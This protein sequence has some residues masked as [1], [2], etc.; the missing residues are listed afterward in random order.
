MESEV[1]NIENAEDMTI[2]I[3]E[4]LTADLTALKSFW[5]S[6]FLKYI[7]A[8]LLIHEQ[9][10][11][12]IKILEKRLDQHFNEVINLKDPKLYDVV[13]LAES[14]IYMCQIKLLFVMNTEDLYVAEFFL[15]RAMILLKNKELCS[16]AIL[17]S[18]RALSNLN[19]V[20]TKLNN[21]KKSSQCLNK[22]M[23][24]YLAYTKGQDEFPAPISVETA[25]GIGIKFNTV[26]VLKNM[27]MNNLTILL[28]LSNRYMYELTDLEKAVTYIHNFLKKQLTIVYKPLSTN[29]IEWALQL[30]QLAEY[31]LSC[32]RFIECKNHLCAATFMMRCYKNTC[33]VSK[34]IPPKEKDIEQYKY[35]VTI[36]DIIW[37]KYG[38]VILYLSGKRLL[39]KEKE[40]LCERNKFKTESTT[41]SNKTFSKLLMFTDASEEFSKF[42]YVMPD[43]YITNYKD[44]KILFIRIIEILNILK[45]GTFALRS[46]KFYAEIAHYTSKAYKY[47]AFY[48][49]DK[50]KQFKLQKRR[51]DV[52]KN[53]LK[54]SA[55]DNLDICMFLWFELGAIYSTLIDIKIENLE[56]S[57]LTTEYLM[58]INSLVKY[59]VSYFELYLDISKE[60]NMCV[61]ANKIDEIMFHFNLRYNKVQEYINLLRDIDQRD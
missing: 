34:D 27:H 33:I 46:T 17:T 59:S 2:N 39:Q 20:F 43:D 45:A 14:F 9:E 44:A 35:I 7:F 60:R 5:E 42:A 8:R 4:K 6:K 22:T 49:H 26:Y 57:K 15:T 61:H 40:D 58:E 23:E 1:E 11:K 53:C 41:Q 50:I 48:E 18:V 19:I 55:K 25:L 16:E 21:V 37:V 31:F 10:I 56:V 30:I 29:Y 36:I 13:A 12:Q 38:L 3:T 51:V 28:Q 32:Y 54:M 24:L 47:L 52:L